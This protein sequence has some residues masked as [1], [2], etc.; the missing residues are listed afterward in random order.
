MLSFENDE[1]PAAEN[2]TSKM[3]FVSSNW[4]AMFAGDP[5]QAI[6]VLRRV[7]PRLPNEGALSGTELLAAMQDSFR[8]AYQSE[9]RQRIT[10]RFLSPYGWTLEEF[11]REAYTTLGDDEFAKLNSALRAYD[12]GLQFLVF[13]LEPR[14]GYIFEV[15]NPGVVTSHDMTGYAVIGSG[16]YMAMGAL[17]ARPLSSSSVEELVYRLCEAKFTSETAHGVGRETTLT[18]LNPNG[19]ESGIQKG[20]VENLRQQWETQRKAAISTYTAENIRSSIIK[21]IN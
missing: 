11:R 15:G 2:A 5:T 13:G 20:L 1:I 9:V 4:R 8:E 14:S 7:Y 16:Y 17:A 19:H 18:V 3:L 6:S 10:D 12:L 21:G